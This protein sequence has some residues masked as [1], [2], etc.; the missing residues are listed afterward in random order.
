M[1]P[2]QPPEFPTAPELAAEK[3]FAEQRAEV[4]AANEESKPSVDADSGLLDQARELFHAGLETVAASFALVRAEFHLA[5]NSAL[6]LLT[7]SCVLIVLA[8]GT[9]LGLLA[10]VAAGVARLAGSWF[11]GIGTVVLL[12]SA[13]GVWVF[14]MIRRAFRDMGMPRTRRMFSGMRSQKAPDPNSEGEDAR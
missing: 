5:R 9:W 1:N 3:Q 13:G 2:D 6:F 14:V 12:N 4:D 8:V 11:V 10:L 7:M